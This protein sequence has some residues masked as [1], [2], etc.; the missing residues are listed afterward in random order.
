MCKKAS[1]NMARNLSCICTIFCTIQ[2]YHYTITILMMILLNIIL[3]K[4]IKE[5]FSI[6]PISLLCL[7]FLLFLTW[8]VPTPV[9]W[10][11]GD[12]DDGSM[13][14]TLSSPLFNTEEDDKH[15]FTE[16]KRNYFIFIIHSA[17]FRETAKL[18]RHGHR[19]TKKPG[20]LAVSSIPNSNIYVRFERDLHC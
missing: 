11:S 20:E 4:I 5:H 13:S 9:Y 2:Q 3:C 19:L 6:I 12:D 8:G 18:S 10:E 1:L 14:L 7:I 17:I 15:I 16:K